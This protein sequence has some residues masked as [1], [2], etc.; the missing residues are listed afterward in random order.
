MVRSRVGADAFGCCAEG[1]CAGA[2]WPKLGRQK[3]QSTT[4][5]GKLQRKMR[6][7]E[8]RTAAISADIMKLDCR[9]ALTLSSVN[10]GAT[11]LGTCF[12]IERKPVEDV[13]L[14]SLAL[15]SRDVNGTSKAA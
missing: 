8:T 7:L 14:R 10:S 9:K 4:T 11:I 3:L 1:C 5:A 12:P 6:G 13:R 2:L 15:L